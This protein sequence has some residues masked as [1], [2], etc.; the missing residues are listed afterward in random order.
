MK[1]FLPIVVGL[2]L[3]GCATHPWHRSRDYS[4]DFVIHPEYVHPAR[5][6]MT[7]G[8]LQHILGPDYSILPEDVPATDHTGVRIVS[9]REGEELY[10]IR[11]VGGV[12]LTDSDVINGIIVTNTRFQ[13]EAGLSPGDPLSKAIE[14]YGKP[15]VRWNKR[16]RRDDV[17]FPG[18]ENTRISLKLLTADGRTALR[19]R[20]AVHVGTIGIGEH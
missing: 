10:R 3:A 7:V 15:S 8:E 9:T 5:P 12:I 14:L 4:G 16:T 1:H 19:F 13:T 11:T 6:G 20:D 18:L 2:L 17:T